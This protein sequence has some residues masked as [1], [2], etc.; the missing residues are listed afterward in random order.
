MLQIAFHTELLKKTAK[1]S[2]FSSF[3]WNFTKVP[4]L[5]KYIAKL[6]CVSHQIWSFIS[7]FESQN[8]F[9]PPVLFIVCS[10][11]ATRDASDG[12]LENYAAC[13]YAMGIQHRLKLMPKYEHRI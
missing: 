11:L 2:V 4:I 6:F 10:K 1:M 9:L 12:D 3:T 8:H 13:I 7:K 5:I